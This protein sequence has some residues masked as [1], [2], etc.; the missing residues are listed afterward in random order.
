MKR[1]AL[2][3][4]FLAQSITGCATDSSSGVGGVSEDAFCDP[5]MAKVDSFMAGF[6]G[7][8]TTDE[9]YGGL[10]VAATIE[11]LRGMSPRAAGGVLSAQH[12]QF[13]NLMTLLEFDENFEPVD[14]SSP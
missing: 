14:L 12:Q 1:F 11:D 2:F 9:R 6:A 13:V 8:E 7:Q 10:A 5:V 4:L 3:L